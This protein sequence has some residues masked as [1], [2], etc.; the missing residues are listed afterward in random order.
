V[1]RYRFVDHCPHCGADVPLFPH[2]HPIVL[3]AAELS[4]DEPLLEVECGNQFCRRAYV[5]T[6][7]WYQRAVPFPDEEP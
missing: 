2:H 7:A 4:P 1:T 3:R 6:A 5:I